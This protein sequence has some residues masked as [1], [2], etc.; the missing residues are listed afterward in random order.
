MQVFV[1][2]TVLDVEAEDHGAAFAVFVAVLAVAGVEQVVNVLCAQREQ[3]KTVGNEFIGEDGV[4]SLS[5]AT[6][7][8]SQGGDAMEVS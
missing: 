6:N 4:V 2:V 5:N 1:R 7:G 8:V 3:T